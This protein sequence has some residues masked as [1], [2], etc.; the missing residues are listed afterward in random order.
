MG[1]LTLRLDGDSRGRKR[2]TILDGFHKRL[3]VKWWAAPNSFTPLCST[4]LQRHVRGKVC[5]MFGGPQ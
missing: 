4:R 2:I 3:A 1:E 5:Q